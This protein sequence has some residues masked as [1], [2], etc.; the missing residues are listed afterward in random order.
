MIGS[1]HDVLP[2]LID[3]TLDAQEYIR[4]DSIQALKARLAF[5]SRVLPR[6][7]EASRNGDKYKAPRAAA[8]LQEIE[9]TPARPMA[10][11]E[12]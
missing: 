6:L 7:R 8:A 3:G 2:E 1:R 9:S 4:R 5:D 12:R 10:G 11:E